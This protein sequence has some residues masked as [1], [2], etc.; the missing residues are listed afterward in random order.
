MCAGLGFQRDQFI[1]MCGEKQSSTFRLLHYP[2]RLNDVESIPDD[3]WDGK[4]AIVT[5]A[6]H[7]TSLMTVLAT[8]NMSGLQIKPPGYALIFR[9]PS[10]Q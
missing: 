8:F 3:A 10:A 2:T 5:G 9:Q 6:H 4:T 1:G 7:D